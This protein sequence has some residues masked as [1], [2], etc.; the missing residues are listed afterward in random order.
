MDTTIRHY[1]ATADEARRLEQGLFRLEGERTREILARMVPAG[2]RILDVGAGAGAYSFW[3]AERGH[4]VHLVDLSPE[5]VARAQAT[6]AGAKVALASIAVGDA[7]SLGGQADGSFDVVLLL[8][9]LYHLLEHADRL[10][11]VREA[12]RVLRPEGLLVAAAI[13]RFASLLDGMQEGAVFD[14]PRFTAIVD[15]DLTTGNH[16][17]TTGELRYFTTAH[18]HAPDELAAELEEAGFDVEHLLAVEG[19]SWVCDDFDR[20]W[21]D[22]ASRRQLLDYARRLEAE[23]SLLGMSPHLIAVG[24]R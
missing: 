15:H 17:N 19:P 7:R 22:E 8:G 2:A 18:F 11:A 12:R 13:S 1:Y 5:L 16:L 23:P 14:D 21:Q 3:L 9:P 24:R 6:Q 20:R 4:E 10:A